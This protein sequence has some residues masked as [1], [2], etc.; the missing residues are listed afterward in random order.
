MD[1][2]DEYFII[3]SA[4]VG[5]RMGKIGKIKPK[6]LF[7]VGKF[8]ILKNIFLILRSRGAREVNLVLGYKY[9]K[10]LNEAKS[11][12]GLK[13]RYIVVDDY[14]NNGSVYSLYKSEN[15]WKNNKKK[16]ILMM[17][18]DLIFD[19]RYLDE[20]IKSKKKLIIC[21]RK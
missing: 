3:L 4:G 18:T 17:H 6:S 13:I 16:L 20:I 2:L 5:E 8:S 7:K 14:I 11:F 19:P 15:L 10:V 12:K 1:K 9:K 21:L